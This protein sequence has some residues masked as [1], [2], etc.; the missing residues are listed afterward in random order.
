MRQRNESRAV[1]ATPAA[2]D[3][4]ATYYGDC[5][6]PLSRR[7]ALTQHERGCICEACFPTVVIRLARL[8]AI[9]AR[10]RE[11]ERRP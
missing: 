5:S 2:A 8:S 11:Q 7:Q 4:T 10:C 6:T 9:V 3:R 1:L